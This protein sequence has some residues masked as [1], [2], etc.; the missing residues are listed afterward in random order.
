MHE[1]EKRS[2]R[3]SLAYTQFTERALAKLLINII[4][5]IAFLL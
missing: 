4:L 2:R 3:D 5:C 1:T